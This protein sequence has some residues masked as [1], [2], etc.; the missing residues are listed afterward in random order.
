M[1][2]NK[3]YFIVLSFVLVGFY[4]CSDLLEPIDDNHSTVD[5]ILNDP[6]FAEGL[7]MT[8][9]T[10]LPT[11]SYSFNDVSTDD[12]V[13]NDKSNAYLRMATGQWS[14]Q[15][16]PVSIWQNANEAILYLNN[17]IPQ[18]DTIKW[19]WT[20]ASIN[21]MFKA[22]LKGEAYALRGIFKYYLLQN[23]GGKSSDGNL[24]GI[25]LFN[26]QLL[27][28][29]NFN[30]PRASFNESVA[31]I[32][33]DFDMAMTYLPLDLKDI[34]VATALPAQF[35]TVAIADYN[36]VFGGVSAQRVSKRIILGYKSRL[37]L[38]AA[39]KAFN[40]TDENSLW[41]AAANASAEVLAGINGL[42]GID[43][44]GNKFYESARVN[45]ATIAT[46]QK[47]ILWRGSSATLSNT[48]E[49]NMLPPSLNG[50]GRINPTQNLIDAF[51]MKNGYPINHVLSGYVASTPYL[52]RDPR[53][54][55]YI[56]RNGLTFKT[57]V[58][59]TGVGGGVDAKDSIPTSTRT[60]Y[61]MRKLIR[62]DIN[63]NND[64]TASGTAK[65]YPVHIRYTEV[66]L[67][68]AEAAN[69]AGG[70][71]F[72]VG[73]ATYTARDVI[74]AIR[75]RAGIT[76]STPTVATG[77]DN[78]LKSISTKEEMRDLIRNERR[79]ELCFEGFR[80]WDIRRWGL[81]LNETATGVN[82]NTTSTTFTKVDVEPR[83]YQ[84]FMQ[85]GPLPQ[86]EVVKFSALKQNV[87]W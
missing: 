64:G 33:A 66:F 68:Y 26:D 21:K 34:T 27:A 67:N 78:Y 61:Y 55:L 28:G 45:A 11:Y 58:I 80:F 84:P 60:G 47:E 10:K 43:A 29:A 50:N 20:N 72:K 13:S 30:M 77:M 74:G 52:N 62:E 25:P 23:V 32:N 37:T 71:D 42:T 83:S 39:S 51:P 54:D 31:S 63:F 70:P 12:A 79:L 53:L 81:V 19:T 4:S 41:V 85:Y 22:R 65:H 87:G 3:L 76:Q 46:D 6:A 73:T 69:E 38:L 9:Y 44:F 36:K 2:I 18:V 1:K 48:L 86:T 40:P 14:A 35:S 82:I 5:R 15:Y 17:F 57:K 75:K 49:K 59:K 56:V 8:A 7:L 16:N 24:L